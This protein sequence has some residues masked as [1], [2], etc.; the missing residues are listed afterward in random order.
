MP[1]GLPMAL[2]IVVAVFKDRADLVAENVALR[3]QLSC[4]VRGSHWPRLRPSDRV[5]WALL[6]RLWRDWRGSLAMVKPAT[7]LSWHRKGG[8][9]EASE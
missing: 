3:Q 8:G 1:L 9:S 7:V 4:F 2:A 5:F 6:S